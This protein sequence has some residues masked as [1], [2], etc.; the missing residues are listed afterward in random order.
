MNL[1]FI[2]ERFPHLEMKIDT[3]NSIYIIN[4]SGGDNIYIYYEP[5]IDEYTFCFSYQHIHCEKEDV[6]MWIDEFTNGKVGAIEFFNGEHSC[7]GGNIDITIVKNL[8]YKKLKKHYLVGNRDFKIR[9][10]DP[11]Y[12]FNGK[13]IRKGL[14]HEILLEKAPNSPV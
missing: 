14:K 4:N 8:T 5:T 2:K 11:K 10:W 7:F 13:I 6:L 12:N 1:T 3:E 9:C